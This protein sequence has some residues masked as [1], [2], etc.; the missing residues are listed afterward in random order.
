MEA[1]I[2]SA[3]SSSSWN[4]AKEKR[5]SPKPNDIPGRGERERKNFERERLTSGNLVKVSKKIWKYR[6]REKKR[7]WAKWGGLPRCDRRKKKHL[8]AK[9]R[10]VQ[11]RKAGNGRSRTENSQRK[12]EGE[13]QAQNGASGQQRAR[14]K[15][16]GNSGATDLRGSGGLTRQ[17]KPGRLR[18]KPTLKGSCFPKRDGQKPKIW[19]GERRPDGG[20]GGKKKSR[21]RKGDHKTIKE[22]EGEKGGDG[23]G[24]NW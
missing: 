22:G 17:E 3:E 7:R 4:F 24:I 15:K 11:R 21:F 1:Q 2:Q 20:R 13:S 23:E 16:K 8:R 12:Q 10:K 14:K 5:E 9:G 19:E 18:R 6:R